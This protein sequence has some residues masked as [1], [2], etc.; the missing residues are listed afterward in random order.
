VQKGVTDRSA[1]R[2][3]PGPLLE[4]S[5]RHDD[6]HTPVGLPILEDRN[7]AI[8]Q[9]GGSLPMEVKASTR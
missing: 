4:A 1:P 8:G 5:Q 6:G 9:S 2:R 7:R 3:L